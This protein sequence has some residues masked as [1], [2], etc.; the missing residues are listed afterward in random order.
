[1]QHT[2]IQTNHQDEPTGQPSGVQQNKGAQQPP[3]ANKTTKEH[4]PA[5]AKS[6]PARQKKDSCQPRPP[7]QQQSSSSSQDT[8]MPTHNITHFPLILSQQP[9][10]TALQHGL[11]VLRDMLSY[12]LHASTSPPPH[13]PQAMA[14]TPPPQPTREEL[15]LTLQ[16]AQTLTTHIQDLA[17]KIMQSHHHNPTSNQPH[18]NDVITIDSQES[19][20]QEQATTTE[21]ATPHDPTTAQAMTHTTQQ[22]TTQSRPEQVPGQ[23]GPPEQAPPTATAGT[24][25]P[26][27]TSQPAEAATQHTGSGSHEATNQPWWILGRQAQRSRSPPERR[28][29]DIFADPLI[30]PTQ[31]MTQYDAG[32]GTSDI[33]PMAEEDE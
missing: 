6:K 31:R 18:H 4:K 10:F 24:A 1:M 15:E 29:V 14:A 12:Q 11:P 27:H 20:T 23:E 21:Q 28:Q 30:E 26:P 3:Q 2:T 7:Q 17:R 19:H 33:L 9:P 8:W 22:T 5:A 13:P 32:D 25:T 16:I